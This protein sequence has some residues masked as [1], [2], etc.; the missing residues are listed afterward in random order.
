V[1][2]ALGPKQL[3]TASEAD[4]EFGPALE[5]W[6]GYASDPDLRY[7]G[8]SGGLL[9]TLALYCLEQENMAF[10]VHAAMDEAK[11]WTNKTVLSRN[12]SEILARTGS[13]YAPASPCDGLRAVEESDRTC[14]FIGKPCDAAGVAL[15]RKQ[16]PELDRKIGLVL[17]F[18]GAGT[19]STRGTLDLVKSLDVRL[20]DIDEVRYRGEGWPGR[21]RIR[22]DNRTQDKS[23]SYVE[24]W[25][26]LTNYRTLRCALCP[27]GLGRIADLSCGDAWER[28]SGD[29]DPGRSIVLVRTERGRAILHRAM[30]AGYVELRPIGAQ[31]VLVA[32]SSLLQ[33][34]RE[35]FGRFL[36]MRLLLIPIPMVTGFSLLH[37]W[38][39][40]PFLQMARTVLGTM[41]R[42]VQRGWWRRNRPHMANC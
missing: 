14:V 38:L 29:S 17:T 21:F 36:A 30:A 1:D 20:E 8:S 15:L 6:E 19:P 7:R 41:R 35:I 39:R 40:L 13:R 12:R 5:I 18:F 2:S 25:G 37:S 28:V 23:Y 32:Q 11:P 26:R 3:P 34:R 16:R 22:Y 42:V 10:V 31:A 24:S 27:D 9:S 4:R 33:R